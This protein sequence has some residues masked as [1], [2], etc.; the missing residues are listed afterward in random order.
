MFVDRI[1]DSEKI[2]KKRDDAFAED[3]TVKIVALNIVHW[4]GTHFRF[5]KINVSKNRNIR[6]A[7]RYLRKV[8]SFI[9][10]TLSHGC[11]FRELADKLL[12]DINIL[13][14]HTDLLS[15]IIRICIH[16]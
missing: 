9:C 13:Y 16:V 5:Y 1:H 14:F 15:N 12:C 8:A 10:L 4:K 3:Q 2:R 7:E 6:Y 11:L